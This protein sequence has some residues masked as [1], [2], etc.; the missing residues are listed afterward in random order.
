MRQNIRTHKKKKNKLTKQKSNP[1]DLYTGET[2]SAIKALQPDLTGSVPRPTRGLTPLNAPDF[3]THAFAHVH[4]H[5][6][7]KL[8]PVF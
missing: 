8:I 4:T 7:S 2:V 3:Y 1:P 6:I 5:T